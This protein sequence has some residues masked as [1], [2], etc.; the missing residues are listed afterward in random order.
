MNNENHVKLYYTLFFWN[1]CSKP[2]SVESIGYCTC[3]VCT[4]PM[5]FMSPTGSVKAVKQK[6][7]YCDGVCVTDDR[8]FQSAVVQLWNRLPPPPRQQ[9]DN[10]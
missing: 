5:P 1:Y 6:K 7:M 9:D 3:W 2:G 4:A 8:C 10:I